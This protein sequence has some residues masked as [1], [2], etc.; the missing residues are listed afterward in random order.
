M[1]KRDDVMSV[2]DSVVRNDCL[3]FRRRQKICLMY[4][5]KTELSFGLSS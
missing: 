1:V 2:R 4:R 5:E 3:A